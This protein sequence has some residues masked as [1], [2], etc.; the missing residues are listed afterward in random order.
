MQ[1]D[2][3]D[4]IVISDD[5]S[6][7]EIH[8]VDAGDLVPARLWCFSPPLNFDNPWWAADLTDED[9][10]M[11][12][13]AAAG[14]PLP[15]P[16]EADAEALDEKDG[17]FV[18]KS[19]SFFLTYPQ[20][21]GFDCQAILEGLQE[22]F[23]DLKEVWVGEEKHK[24]GVNHYHVCGK[25]Q[26]KKTLRGADCFDLWGEFKLH[27]NIQ[28][29]KDWKKVK[30]YVTKG[31]K[32]ITWGVSEFDWSTSSGFL[33]RKC[34]HAAW[35]EH[36]LNAS[37]LQWKGF[38]D[39]GITKINTNP[40]LKRRH[41]WIYGPSSAGK[42]TTLGLHLQKYKTYKVTKSNYPYERYSDHDIVWWDS[43]MPEG[44][45]CIDSISEY[46]YIKRPFYGNHRYYSAMHPLKKN[47]TMI[48]TH[49]EPPPWWHEEWF[50]T[51]FFV[52]KF[53]HF[54]RAAELQRDPVLDNMPPLE[55]VPE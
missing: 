4:V 39:L 53:P 25:F 46:E 35:E 1:A 6:D 18:F 7:Q 15:A 3:K 24:D 27:P 12:A 52:Y 17:P 19:K 49:N 54:S 5:E 34:D 47:I 32:F 11:G 33:K 8:D 50:Q 28:S 20:V 14:P 16:E 31:G 51:R 55:D 42:S 9:A 44:Q 22:I 30:K 2:R 29:P 48:V 21:E 10:E 41:F 38:L 45:E 23:D 13:A 40:N 43:S 36:A 37:K 26:H